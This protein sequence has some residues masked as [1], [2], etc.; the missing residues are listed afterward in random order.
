MLIRI[1]RTCTSRKEHTYAQLVMRVYPDRL[2]NPFEGRLLKTGSSVELSEL[3]PTPEYPEIPLLIEFA[4]N[5]RTGSGHRRSNDVHVLW[6]LN[7]ST[8]EW[9]ELVKVNGQG[10]DWV[11]Y[12]RPIVMRQLAAASEP[13]SD[14]AARARQRVLRLLDDE[15]ERLQ[16]SGRADLMTTLYDEIAARLMT[17]AA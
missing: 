9:Q 1:P 6:R 14:L 10:R 15:L 2:I 12:L 3:R 4:G 17:W 13:Y 7:P 16:R 8:R 11:E 5:D